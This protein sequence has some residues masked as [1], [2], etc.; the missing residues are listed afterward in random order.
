MWND[1]ELAYYDGRGYTIRD[2]IDFWYKNLSDT[3]EGVVFRDLCSGPH[4]SNTC[5]EKI[6]LETESAAEEWSVAAR[7]SI[8]AVVLTIAVVCLLLKVYTFD[9]IDVHICSSHTH[10][11]MAY[12]ILSLHICSYTAACGLCDSSGCRSNS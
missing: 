10:P 11:V 1:K 9:S 12:N 2:A 3:E 8:A 7:I 4:C 6:I 5:P